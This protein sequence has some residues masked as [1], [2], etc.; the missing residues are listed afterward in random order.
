MATKFV[1]TTTL[2]DCAQSKTGGVVRGA[3]SIIRG[4]LR[5]SINNLCRVRAK[6][7]LR[8]RTA[9]LQSGERLGKISDREARASFGS[10]RDNLVGVLLMFFC[11]F[12]YGNKAG[13][14]ILDVQYTPR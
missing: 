1:K 3:E 7:K 2:S 5:A 11:G 8:A 6:S 14:F 12:Q 4:K 13:R 9:H 10:V